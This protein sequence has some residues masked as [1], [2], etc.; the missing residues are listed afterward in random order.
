MS[1]NGDS[2]LGYHDPATMS[3]TFMIFDYDYY[4]LDS[5][6]AAISS[7]CAQNS[8]SSGKTFYPGVIRSYPSGNYFTVSATI[9]NLDASNIPSPSSIL[10]VRPGSFAGTPYLYYMTRSATASNEYF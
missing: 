5:A 6:S 10:V 7:Y 3:G 8:D 2:S 1:Q 4:I 9:T